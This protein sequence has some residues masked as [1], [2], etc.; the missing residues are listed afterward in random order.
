MTR[1]NV[2]LAM[3]GAGVLA[4]AMTAD[5][6]QAPVNQQ[7]PLVNQN[8]PQPNQQAA[9]ASRQAA[10]ASPDAAPASQKEAPSRSEAR[11]RGLTWLSE[12]QAADGSWGQRYKL[13]VTSF[14]C[15]ARLAT[16]E[17]P[18]AGPGGRSLEKGLNYILAQQKDGMFAQQ[19]GNW[20]HGQGF[21]TLALSEA[22]GRS[23]TCKTKPDMDMKAVREVVAK[24]V[25]QIAAHQSNSGGWWYTPGNK[26]GHEGSTT[27][28]AVQALVSADNYGIP[29]DKEVL[30]RGFEY[31]KQCQNPD[32]GF[33]Y[34]LGPGNASMKEGT[35]G[36]VATLGLMQKFDY[37]VMMKGY[38]FLLK[39]TPQVISR[40][41]FPYYGHFYG[42]MGMRL[43][44]QEF[45]DFRDKTDGYITG[46]QTDVLSWQRPDGS[47][48]IRGSHLT[49]AESED[50][51]TAF[52]SLILSI[53][54]GRLSIFNR[55][56]PKPP[57]VT[58]N[59]LASLTI[60]CKPGNSP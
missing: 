44:G 47:W 8:M 53:P 3:V 51:A 46:A 26:N 36:G 24:A 48:P 28:C 45:K 50:Y 18:F 19:G 35:A 30:A 59:A 43:L 4:A 32:G 56:K 52:A 60:A 29:I 6:R 9:P 5:E 16:D 27:V 55:Q 15:L 34:Q 1:F 31:L 22:Y 25:G 12:H 33:D 2:L 20:I 11:D 14:S 37:L 13:A 41:R 10:P 57:T 49:G 7:A 54:D 40:E 23:L 39:T 17:D 21:A 58:A 38:Q 42:I